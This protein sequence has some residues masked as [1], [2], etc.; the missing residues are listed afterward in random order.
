MYIHIYTYVHLHTHLIISFRSTR[1]GSRLESTNS[2]EM[3]FEMVSHFFWRAPPEQNPRAPQLPRYI[4][5]VASQSCFRQNLYLRITSRSHWL[6]NPRMYW[7]FLDESLN[8]MLSR[9]ARRC[10]DFKFYTRTF[11]KFG[12]AYSINARR[13]QKN[14]QCVWPSLR[15][16]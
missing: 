10:Y 2:K 6:G 16:N 1:Y 12:I 14:E 4:P 8:G 9:C 5:R 3:C 11:V 13:L 7:N 15:G